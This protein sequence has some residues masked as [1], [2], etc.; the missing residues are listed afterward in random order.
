MMINLLNWY[1]FTYLMSKDQKYKTYY[2][3]ELDN[4]VEEINNNKYTL[5]LLQ[6]PDGLKYYT[7]E[8]IDELKEKTKAD[9]ITYFGTCF[10]ACDVPLHL[11]KLG[12]DLVVQWGHTTFIKTKGMW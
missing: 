1:K 6:L 7:K 4:L 3:L 10:G 2:D 12:F 8:I 5:V 9:F 11:E